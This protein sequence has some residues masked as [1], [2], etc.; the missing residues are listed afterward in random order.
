MSK[1][2]VK[3]FSKKKRLLRMMGDHIQ[4]SEDA[5]SGHDLAGKPHSVGFPG[6][7]LELYGVLRYHNKV[8]ERAEP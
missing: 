2:S 7:L 4:A 6:E 8:F 1:S 5:E 3:P